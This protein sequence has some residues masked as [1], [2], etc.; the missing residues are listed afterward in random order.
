[1]CG[2]FTQF[3]SWRELVD[4]YGLSGTPLNLEPRYNIAP[5]TSVL[6][7]HLDGNSRVVSQMRWGL[8]P[9]WWK[10]ENRLPATFNARSD[11]VATKPMFRSAFK[12]RR[13][14]VPMSGFFEWRTEVKVKRPFYVTMTSGQPMSV[15]G[16]WLPV[17][18]E[19]KGHVKDAVEFLEGW[20]R[21]ASPYDT[22][23][24]STAARVIG[25]SPRDFNKDVRRHE[26]FISAIAELGVVEW[27]Q[28]ERFSAFMS[29]SSVPTPRTATGGKLR[30]RA[31]ST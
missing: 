4:L 22:L 28:G 25:M 5:T 19:L 17:E 7:V 29:I 9:T 23:P 30:I 3:Y 16:I 14:I 12:S 10:E 31:S 11:T 21:W 8:I 18:R 2:R 26:H 6:T 27:G 20:V 1:M 15:A 24:F 13:C